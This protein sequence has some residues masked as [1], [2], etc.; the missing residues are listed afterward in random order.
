MSAHGFVLA[1]ASPRR[2]EILGTLGLRF[3]VEVSAIDRKSVV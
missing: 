2:R 1:S 3:D